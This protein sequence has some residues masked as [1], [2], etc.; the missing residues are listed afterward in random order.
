MPRQI[1]QPCGTR[2]RTLDE[3]LFLRTPALRLHL[4][5]EAPGGAGERVCKTFDAVGTCG[6]IVTLIQMDFV[7]Q[8]QLYILAQARRNAKGSTIR[9]SH[10]P[11]TADKASVV[12]RSRFV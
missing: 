10:P 9:E 5:E 7:P 3:R 12:T 1:P 4:L 2:N 6:W 11:S 8:Q